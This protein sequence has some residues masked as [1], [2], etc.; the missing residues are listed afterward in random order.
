MTAAYIVANAKDTKQGIIGL[1]T[2][3]FESIAHYSV[4]EIT[5]A[6]PVNNTTFKKGIVCKASREYI[7]LDVNIVIKYGENVSQI[8]EAVQK[9]IYDTVL[10]M[11]MVAIDN[12]TI[13]VVGFYN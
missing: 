1:S 4:L 3:V 13:N 5:N 11:T 2:A 7:S 6:R 8:S 12:I 10:S 9:H